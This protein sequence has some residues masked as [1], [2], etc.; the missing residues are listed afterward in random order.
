MFIVL[1]CLPPIPLD[2]CLCKQ[3]PFCFHNLLGGGVNKWVSLAL[4]RSAWVR[5]YLLRM[6]TK[7]VVTSLKRISHTV[8]ATT[9]LRDKSLLPNSLLSTLQI[10]S[11]LWAPTNSMRDDGQAQ[12]C[13]SLVQ[14]A[15]FVMPWR[16]SR[17]SSP[18][19]A[20]LT[21]LPGSCRVIQLSHSEHSIVFCSHIWPLM[22]FSAQKKLPWPESTTAPIYG[23]KCKWSEGNV[24]AHG[25]SAKQHYFFL[26]FLLG[27]FL[28]YISN[29]IP[30][31]PHTH[32]P[33]PLPTHSPFLALA[34]PCTGAYKV[35]KSNGP[36]FPVMAD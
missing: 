18:F 9:I 23:H 36:L 26:N 2:I 15:P 33:T 28:I 8:L 22:S 17:H 1:F 31:I 21:M 24:M 7:L 30:K 10:L 11:T 16:V 5:G 29:A 27:I 25:H 20:A 12:L 14:S 35:C 34:F 3:F 19:L 4:L 13:P 6:G 32:S